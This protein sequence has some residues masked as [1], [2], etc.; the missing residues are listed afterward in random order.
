VAGDLNK[1]HRLSIK[2]LLPSQ[3]MAS[4]NETSLQRRK[5]RRIPPTQ[6]RFGSLAK[7]FF[8]PQE[9]TT[10]VVLGLRG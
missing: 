6:E 7:I 4:E 1:A 8:L 2:M 9:R 10:V 5:L 3:I